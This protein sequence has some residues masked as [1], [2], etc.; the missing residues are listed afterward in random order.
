MMHCFCFGKFQNKSKLNLIKN[1]RELKV[2]DWETQ[3]VWGN[4]VQF[5][6]FY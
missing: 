6:H 1:L 3:D 5:E 2:Q 4:T